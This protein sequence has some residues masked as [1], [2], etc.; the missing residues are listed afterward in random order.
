MNPQDVEK[1]REQVEG[2]ISSSRSLSDIFDDLCRLS[3]TMDIEKGPGGLA[4]TVRAAPHTTFRYTLHAPLNALQIGDTLTLDVRAVRLGESLARAADYLPQ[5]ARAAV[6]A[7]I[8]DMRAEYREARLEGNARA[9]RL[10]LWRG[11]V[12][13]LLALVK[14]LL[15]LLPVVRFFLS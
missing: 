11:H 7:A 5:K 15:W 13:A 10:A 8:A 4:V 14:S 12:S 2:I 3:G 1:L 9:A 6:L